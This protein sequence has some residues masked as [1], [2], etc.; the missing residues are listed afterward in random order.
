MYAWRLIRKKISKIS[1]RM[2]LNGWKSRHCINVGGFQFG[3]AL[4]LQPAGCHQCMTNQVLSTISK[5]MPAAR[6]DIRKEIFEIFFLMS[7]HAD[8]NNGRARRFIQVFGV[9]GC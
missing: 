9:G 3:L 4:W 6:R 5:K 7:L 2:S 1:L 8:M